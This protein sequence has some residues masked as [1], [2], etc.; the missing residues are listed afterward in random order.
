MAFS[1][2]A[3]SSHKKFNMTRGTAVPLTILLMRVPSKVFYVATVLDLFFRRIVGWLMDISM[4][5][6]L[7]NQALLLAVRKRQPKEMIFFH[8]EQ[9]CQYGNVNY[10]VFLRDINLEL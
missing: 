1:A 10:L 4:D 9:S 2:L 5:R 6:H 7:V 8:S 3:A